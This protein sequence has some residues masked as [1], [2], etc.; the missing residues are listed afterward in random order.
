MSS[1]SVLPPPS[2]RLEIAAAT[3]KGAKRSTNEDAYGLLDLPG[4]D[5]A[6]VIADGMGGLSAGDVA[7]GEAVAAIEETLRERLDRKSVV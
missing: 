1:P 4:A 3:D 2:L 6:V 7:S 5:A